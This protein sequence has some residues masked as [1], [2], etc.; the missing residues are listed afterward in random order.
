MMAV[1]ERQVDLPCAI[2][3]ALHRVRRGMPVVEIAGD[4]NFLGVR[5]AADEIYRLG[6]SFGG[7][8]VLGNGKGSVRTVH[9][10]SWTS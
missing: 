7:I 3:L 4:K 6:H 2:G 1:G 8:T 9:G 5:G 10:D